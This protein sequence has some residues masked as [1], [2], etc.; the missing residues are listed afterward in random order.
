MRFL[1][2]L[3]YSGLDENTNKFRVLNIKLV[4]DKTDC[5][6]IIDKVIKK[7]NIKYNL[8][9][10]IENLNNNLKDV[11]K[12]KYKFDF[13]LD[14]GKDIND[15]KLNKKYLK[16]FKMMLFESNNKF[17]KIKK[18]IENKSKSK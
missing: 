12:G 7:Y 15:I 5:N 6:N 4:S 3:S 1:K 18:D 9:S 17:A 14:E 10:I 13:C 2:Y 16:R 8:Y 11:Y